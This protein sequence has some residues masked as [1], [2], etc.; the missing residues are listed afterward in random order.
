MLNLGIGDKLLVKQSSIP[1]VSPWGYRI[2]FL[3]STIITQVS[4]LGASYVEIPLSSDDFGDYE[5]KELLLEILNGSGNVTESDTF[6]ISD[7]FV[8]LE[9][10]ELLTGLLGENCK[11]TSDNENDYENGHEKTK[12]I[13]IYSDNDLSTEIAEYSW[14]QTFVSNFRPDYRYQRNKVIQKE[15]I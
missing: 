7:T 15:S 10:I 13:N 11:I 12:V 1:I 9:K 8:D 2:V 14:N 3:P 4:G 6:L 5:G